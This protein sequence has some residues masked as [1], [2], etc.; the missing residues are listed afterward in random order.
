MRFLM[1]MIPA[2]YQN[3]LPADFAPPAD[4]VEKMTA[5]NRDL[6]K[7]GVMLTAEGLHP[8]VSGVR[9]RFGGAKPTVIDGPFAESKELIGGYWILSVKSREEAVE[10]AK[11]C[12][13]YEGDVIELREIYEME[14]FPADVQAAAKL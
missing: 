12:P 14:D 2:V 6:L 10:W 7:A 4:A 8:P 5:Y 9:V 11:R 1:M 3:D 13:A